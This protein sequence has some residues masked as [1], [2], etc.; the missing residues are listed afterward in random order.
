MFNADIDID[1]PDRQKLLDLIWHVSARQEKTDQGVKHRSGVYV[2]DVPYDA[3]NDCA[4]IDYHEAEDRGYIK[5][6]LLNMSVYEMVRDPEHYAQL[7]SQEPDWALLD[8]LEFTQQVVHIG[9]HWNTLQRMPEPVNSIPRMAAF[10]S[11]IRPG[12]AHLQGKS[13]A[14]VFASVWDGDESR[15]YTFKKSHAIGYAK[16]VALHINLLTEK[17]CTSS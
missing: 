10:I 9:N 13:W 14:E 11:I 17:L 3:F 15:G 1:L 8:N 2:T 6:D 5:L 4:S 16:L 7:V 12:K